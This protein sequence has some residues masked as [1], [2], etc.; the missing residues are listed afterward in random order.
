M[1]CNVSPVFEFNE[2]LFP[3]VSSCEQIIRG[4]FLQLQVVVVGGSFVV[5]IAG[6]GVVALRGKVVQISVQELLHFVGVFGVP[7]VQILVQSV[8]GQLLLLAAFTLASSA[9]STA[10]ACNDKYNV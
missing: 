10:T 5:G 6:R 3:H 9:T 1:F 4:L 8:L 2:I 7:A